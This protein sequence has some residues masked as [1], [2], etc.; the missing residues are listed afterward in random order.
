[1]FSFAEHNTKL[2]RLLLTTQ[3]LAAIG[4]PLHVKSSHV[5]SAIVVWF[6]LLLEAIV[7]PTSNKPAGSFGLLW[8]FLTPWEVLMSFH[9][10]TAMQPVSLAVS[11]YSAFVVLLSGMVHVFF[12]WHTSSNRCNHALGGPWYQYYSNGL[13]ELILQKK[14]YL[15]CHAGCRSLPGT[16]APMARVQTTC[17]KALCHPSRWT[18]V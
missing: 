11:N 10:P 17:E 1:M 9:V 18:W 7:L 6:S 12:S 15:N 3:D 16:Y 14:W 4:C 2:P 13:K 5:S 8:S